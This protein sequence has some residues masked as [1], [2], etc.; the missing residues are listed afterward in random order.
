MSHRPDGETELDLAESTRPHQ[1]RL[2]AAYDS[3]P[4]SL[5][6][7]ER[8]LDRLQVVG[9]PLGRPAAPL[10]EQ[11][12]LLAQIAPPIFGADLNRMQPCLTCESYASRSVRWEA[13]G[14]PERE[15]VQKPDE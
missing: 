10:D 7:L 6:V 2:Q 4:P 14:R 13:S 12:Q 3:P 11:P 1:R 5:G 9:D 8:Q 15:D